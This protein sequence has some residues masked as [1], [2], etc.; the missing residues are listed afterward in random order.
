MHMHMHSSLH[1][2]LIRSMAALAVT[3][4]LVWAFGLSYS[5]SS[6][7][8]FQNISTNLFNLSGDIILGGLFPINDLTS[9]LSQRREPDNI[10]C[11]R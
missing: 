6:P 8:W 3:L 4:V 5:A 9:N 7:E 2:R 1:L 10:S 11:E